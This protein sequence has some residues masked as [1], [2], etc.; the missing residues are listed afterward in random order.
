MLPDTLSLNKVQIQ[1]VNIQAQQPQIGKLMKEMIKQ[2]NISGFYNA[3][4]EDAVQNLQFNQIPQL[5]IHDAEMCYRDAKKVQ[6][7]Q[8]LDVK[9]LS[10][11]IKE[12]GSDFQ[13]ASHYTSPLYL[14]NLTL[15]RN[16]VRDKIS[17]KEKGELSF[18]VLEA[19][20]DENLEGL[21][22]DN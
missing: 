1:A 7:Q 11:M 16:E 8:L 4:G 10:K 6:D 15:H 9:Q 20:E 19:E 22:L 21:N 12:A 13:I 18:A 3:K 2:L 5:K 17:F 14:A